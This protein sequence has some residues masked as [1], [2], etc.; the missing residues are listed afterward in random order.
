M[1]DLDKTQNYTSIG[2]P[3]KIWNTTFISVFIA[4]ML[5]FLGQQM[6]NTLVAKYADYLGASP[7][8]VGFVTSSF[9]YTA[10]I[11]KVIAAPA[12]DT[13]NKKYVLTGALLVMAISFT[14]Y[15]FAGSVGSLMGFRLLQGAGQ[16]FTATCCLALA[17]N[18]LPQ[19]KMATG[20]AYFS[21]AQAICQA[22]G[23]TLGLSLATTIGYNRT[24][25]IGACIMVSA[26]VAAIMIRTPKK[27]PSQP[28]PKLKISVKRIIAVE[29]VIPAILAFFLSMANY[30]INSFLAIYGA[31]RG[32]ETNIGYF[33]TVYALTMLLSRPLVGRMAD[34]HGIVKMLILSMGCFA[35]AFLLISFSTNIWMFLVSAFVSAFGFGACHPLVQALCMKCVPPNKRG[36]GSIT[37][38]IGQDLGNLVGPTA[39]GFVVERMGY[40]SMWRVMMIPIF[41]AMLIVIFSR[42]YIAKVSNG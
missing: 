18:A 7:S 28:R 42:Q 10:L 9:A 35:F 5:M 37:N 20:I 1:R 33:F 29:A 13:Y 3:D 32:C 6:M 39:A 15:G 17:S 16:A 19:N 30:N 27:D 21:L 40:A 25:I 34:K 26:A 36:A 8:V 12:I 22:I 14:G 38:Y 24:F 11:F 2:A 4:N 41:I 23:P 31:E